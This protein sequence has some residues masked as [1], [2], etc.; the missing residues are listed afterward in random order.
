MS[1]D[2]PSPCH[3]ACKAQHVTLCPRCRLHQLVPS[4]G[5]P[6]QADHVRSQA[7]LGVKA[8]AGLCFCLFA[9]SASPTTRSPHWKEGGEN[10]YVMKPSPTGISSCLLQE[11]HLVPRSLRSGPS[12][13]FCFG[14]LFIK[15]SKDL[16][17]VTRLPSIN[18][19]KKSSGSYMSRKTM[20]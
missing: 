13:G 8:D 19:P 11:G 1:G 20:S 7:S 17:A 4:N 18:M 10:Q 3:L 9:P 5:F 2:W 14:L 12:F 16:E 15:L 6:T